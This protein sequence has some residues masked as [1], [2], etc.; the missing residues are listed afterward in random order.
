MAHL[1]DLTEHGTHLAVSPRASALS[2]Q[3]L[4][5]GGVS[6]SEVVC[7]GGGCKLAPGLWQLWP[8]GDALVMLTAG[9]R[10]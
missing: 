7:G 4:K 9:A 5:P 8:Q 3:R 1:R 6:S 2:C 10:T